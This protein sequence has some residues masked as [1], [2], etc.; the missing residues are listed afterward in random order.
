[1]IKHEEI[2]SQFAETY[3]YQFSYDG[4]FAHS[5]SPYEDAGNV[6]HGSELSYIFCSGTSCTDNSYPEEDLLARQRLI[7][8]WTNF[9]KYQ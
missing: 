9:A 5:E 8:L 7:T 2:F 3:F 1:M 4:S 6:G